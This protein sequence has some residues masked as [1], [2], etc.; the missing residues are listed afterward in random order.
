MKKIIGTVLCLSLL[1]TT[2][3]YHKD[4]VSTTDTIRSDAAVRTTE[5][6][7]TVYTF[8]QSSITMDSTSEEYVIEYDI[9]NAYINASFEQA[10]ELCEEWTGLDLEAMVQE[11]DDKMWISVDQDGYDI[12]YISD[13]PAYLY[14]LQHNWGG[15]YAQ[16]YEYHIVRSIFVNGIFVHEMEDEYWAEVMYCRYYDGLSAEGLI[17]EESDPESGYF[18][19]YD[20]E[21]YAA[22]YLSGNCITDYSHSLCSINDDDVDAYLD[23]CETLGLPTS[24]EM[25]DA[26]S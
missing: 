17:L 26:L 6:T 2:S 15:Y 19:W 10:F 24:V 8:T 7:S 14:M 9:D 20:N 18:Y 4:A 25:T 13:Y 1:M 11:T 16:D 22:L 5:E 12:T 23:M 21:E 3:C